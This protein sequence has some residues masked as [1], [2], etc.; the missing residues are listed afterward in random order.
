MI[1]EKDRRNLYPEEATRLKTKNGMVYKNPELVSISKSGGE[2]ITKWNVKLTSL[3]AEEQ[4]EVIRS[5]L[6]SATEMRLKEAGIDTETID[7]IINQAD[8]HDDLW[9]DIIR[10]KEAYQKAIFY[11]ICYDEVDGIKDDNEL[12]QRI[13]EALDKLQSKIDGKWNGILIPESNIERIVE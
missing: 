10:G 6:R 3:P 12:R 5:S 9:V 11:D 2:V 7:T 13:I 8:N 4:N 1:P